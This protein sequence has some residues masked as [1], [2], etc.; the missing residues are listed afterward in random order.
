MP[1]SP[2]KPVQY[3]SSSTTTSRN[4]NTVDPFY[5]TQDS[6]LENDRVRDVKHYNVFS[7]NATSEQEEEDRRPLPPT[8]AVVPPEFNRKPIVAVAAPPPVSPPPPPSPV[9]QDLH[10]E[11]QEGPIAVKSAEELEALAEAAQK[12]MT[13]SLLESHSS[14]SAKKLGDALRKRYREEDEMEEEDVAPI[15]ISFQ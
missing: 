11:V 9:F 5:S 6:S 2:P 7:Q 14:A 4:N 15:S 10:E 8:T 12:T 13:A 1:S 3:P